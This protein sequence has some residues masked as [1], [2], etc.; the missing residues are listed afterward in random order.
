MKEAAKPDAT[1]VITETV[2]EV[3]EKKKSSKDK[4]K[5]DYT[6]IINHRLELISSSIEIIKDTLCK[7]I[8]LDNEEHD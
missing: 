8:C 4:L 6:N 3:P 2:T 1:I 7:V 5:E